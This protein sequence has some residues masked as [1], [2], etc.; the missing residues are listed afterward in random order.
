MKSRS[1]ELRFDT[2]DN[3]WNLRLTATGVKQINRLA[4]A[5]KKNKQKTFTSGDTT[6]VRPSYQTVRS[7]PTS[8]RHPEGH[9]GLPVLEGDL[10]LGPH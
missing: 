7:C 2:F 3:D 9:L 5:E 1:L 6:G 10:V 8:A 4:L